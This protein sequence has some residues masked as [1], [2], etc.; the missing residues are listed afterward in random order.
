MK[1]TT[2][3]KKIIVYINQVPIILCIYYIIS[4]ICIYFFTDVDIVKTDNG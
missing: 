2:I 3:K 1:T 4:L